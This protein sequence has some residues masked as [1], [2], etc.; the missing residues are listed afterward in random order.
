MA[1][2]FHARGVVISV[3][4]RLGPSVLVSRMDS[5]L[6]GI[7]LRGACNRFHHRSIPNITAVG[8]RG[9]ATSVNSEP[10]EEVAAC[11]IQCVRVNP[12]LDAEDKRIVKTDK[13]GKPIPA[14]RK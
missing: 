11:L 10:A 2:L 1:G 4:G 12:K 6:G 9:F 7:L 14:K 8:R 5:W 13:W 3:W